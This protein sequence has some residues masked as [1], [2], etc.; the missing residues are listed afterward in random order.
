MK[1]K[2][3]VLSVLCIISAQR[4]CADAKTFFEG[5]GEGIFGIAPKNAKLSFDILNNYSE[6]IEVSTRKVTTA[7][8]GTYEHLFYNHHII[9][10]YSS[11]LTLKKHKKSK[12]KDADV[13]VQAVAKDDDQKE[14]AGQKN[15]DAQKTDSSQDAGS[16]DRGV[17]TNKW[18]HDMEYYQ[19]L[20]MTLSSQ[21]PTDLMLHDNIT[22]PALDYPKNVFFKQYFL[23]AMP[24]TSVTQYYHV[25]TGKRLVDGRLRYGPM[26]EMLG[27]FDAKADGPA[28]QY[29]ITFDGQLDSIMFFNATDKDWIISCQ[30]DGALYTQDTVDSAC[31]AKLQAPDGKSLAGAKIIMKDI[32]TKKNVTHIDVPDIFPN[33]PGQDKSCTL[34]LYQS[35][36]KYRIGMQGFNTN[37]KDIPI[38]EHIKDITPTAITVWYQAAQG[39]QAN[40]SLTP[41]DLPGSVWYVY[42]SGKKVTTKKLIPGSVF[43]EQLFRP[44][45]ADGIAYVY[46]LYIQSIDDSEAQKFITD[47]V[48]GAIKAPFL[49]HYKTIINTPYSQDQAAKANAVGGQSMFGIPDHKTISDQNT[50]LSKE[51]IAQ[52]MSGQMGMDGL[53]L[54]D[55]QLLSKASGGQE[56]LQGYLIGIDVF[57]PSGVSSKNFYYLLAPSQ[58]DWAAFTK[59]VSQYID[60]DKVQTAGVDL[61]R[62]VQMVYQQHVVNQAAAETALENFL[63]QYGNA[64]MIDDSGNLTKYGKNRLLSLLDGPVSFSHPPLLLSALQS[65]FTNAPDGLPAQTASTTGTPPTQQNNTSTLPVQTNSSSVQKQLASQKDTSVSKDTTK[66][67][68]KKK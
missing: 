57:F 26:V 31:F 14:Q 9:Q 13:S 37:T 17:T 5:L 44:S 8:G 64:Q 39:G 10:A 67:S 22:I 60:T 42:V 16:D 63:K 28:A 4:M 40:G 58:M 29:N 18:Y 48:S 49:E 11:T 7:M 45:V 33:I 38:S 68:T 2:K 52:V 23:Q 35:G 43:S 66:K 50:Q 24:V 25:Y 56:P 41:I 51:V 54:Q 12:D 27:V 34:E 65:L 32:A 55:E 46:F 61:N 15:S 62:F 30:V 53:K 21:Q 36:G 47:F 3:I 20:F 6:N 59:N 19:G 1:Y